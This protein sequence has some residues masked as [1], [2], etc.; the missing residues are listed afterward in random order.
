MYVCVQVECHKDYI[1]LNHYTSYIYRIIC[2]NIR[3]KL[4]GSNS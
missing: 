1:D 3:T 4:F 2:T